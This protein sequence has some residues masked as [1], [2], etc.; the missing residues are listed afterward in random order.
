MVSHWCLA[1]LQSFGAASHQIPQIHSK[2]RRGS[3]VFGNTQDMHLLTDAVLC[4]RAT[5]IAEHL[6]R[7]NTTPQARV[8]GR[9]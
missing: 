5:A 4:V 6:T 8:R 3:G 9:V 7:L 1:T 2:P